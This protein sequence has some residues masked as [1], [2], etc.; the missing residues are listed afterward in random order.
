MTEWQQ[1]EFSHDPDPYFTW[2]AK[3][4]ENLFGA[5]IVASVPDRLLP[6]YGP[7]L[8]KAYFVSQPC[9]GSVRFQTIRTCHYGG[10]ARSTSYSFAVM[11]MSRLRCHGAAA[12]ARYTLCK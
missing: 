2:R 3:S 1:S 6:Q 11:T 4:S 5:A 9:A 7:I 12:V 8:T 10:T